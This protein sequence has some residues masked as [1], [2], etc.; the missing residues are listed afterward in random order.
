MR[1]KAI[2]SGKTP[3]RVKEGDATKQKVEWRYGGCHACMG[4]PCPIRA[5]VVDGKVVKI[6][7]IR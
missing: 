3:M 6:E 1:P 4:K 5:K 7:R 2:G